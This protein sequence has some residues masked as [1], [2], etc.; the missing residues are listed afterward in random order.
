MKRFTYAVALLSALLPFNILRAADAIVEDVADEG[1]TNRVMPKIIV[2]PPPVFP[3]SLVNSGAGGKVMVTFTVSEDG[4]VRDA[5][6]TSSPQRQLNP[7]AIKAVGSWR[8]EP[9]TRNGQPATFRLR[10]QV[11]FSA[12]P[13]PQTVKG[14]SPQAV[15][16]ETNKPYD[17]APIV[18]RKPTPVYPYEM[19]MSGQSGSADAI[20]VV[21][22]VGRPLFTTA[23]GT[24]NA[25]LAKAAIA[26]V[27]ASEYTPGRKGA[28]RVM[29]PTTEHFQFD[30]EKS[31]NPEARR[32]LAELRKPTPAILSL[33]ELDERPKVLQQVAPAYPR[34]LKDDGLTGQAEIEFVVSRNGEVLFPRI[35]SATHE[36]FGWAAT[37]AVA[38]WRYQPP[39]KNG[40]NVEVRM[41][42][43]ILFTAQKL[44]EMD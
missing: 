41:R 30:G 37:V 15:N 8:F 10:G 35:V 4:S 14:D 25:T 16:K 9:G 29:S 3:A 24:G 22:Y 17:V 23:G 32:V 42:V 38:Q 33:T 27:E 31:L 5:V 19:V 44:A 40:K 13:P 12:T 6:V 26:M 28:Q 2:Q 43:P 18:K 7:Y 20:F 39:Q 11:E 36:D 21:D 34:A 1:G